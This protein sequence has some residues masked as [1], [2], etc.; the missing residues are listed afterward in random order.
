MVD[1]RNLLPEG[2]GLHWK[3]LAPTAQVPQLQVIA[4]AILWAL[5]HTLSTGGFMACELYLTKVATETQTIKREPEATSGY[6]D[7]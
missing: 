4:A 3:R 1:M 7:I 2:R 5:N 6:E